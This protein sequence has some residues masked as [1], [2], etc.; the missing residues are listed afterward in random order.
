[1]ELLYN[2]QPRLLAAVPAASEKIYFAAADATRGRQ[3]KRPA[4]RLPPLF[5]DAHC[6]HFA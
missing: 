6:V 2:P 1:M 3:L 4:R 5:I